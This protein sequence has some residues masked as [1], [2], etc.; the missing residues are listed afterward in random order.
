MEF[1]QGKG[2]KKLKTVRD[3][4]T[5]EAEESF[6]KVNE[7]AINQYAEEV[8]QAIEAEMVRIAREYG[9]NIPDNP[10]IEESQ[11]LIEVMKEDGFEIVLEQETK[12]I[13]QEDKCVYSV[14]I[15]VK[16]VHTTIDFDIEEEP[17]EE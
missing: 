14:T 13:P 1:K 12:L 11:R 9:Y 16:Q 8:E 4:Q 5:G 10:T 3:F 7:E 17:E 6:K 2:F 15:S